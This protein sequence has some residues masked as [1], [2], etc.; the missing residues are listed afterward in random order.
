MLSKIRKYIPSSTLSGALTRQVNKYG[1]STWSISDDVLC[2]VTDDHRGFYVTACIKTDDPHVGGFD[3]SGQIFF[4][5]MGYFSDPVAALNYLN[6]QVTKTKNVH[7]DMNFFRRLLF[8]EEDGFSYF[9]GITDS[10][11]LDISRWLIEALQK[12]HR[13][14]SIYERFVGGSWQLTEQLPWE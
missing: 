10:S 14:V 9:R 3:I 4:Y 5:K 6:V 1:K 7:T 8:T 13:H 11:E 2:D 12:P